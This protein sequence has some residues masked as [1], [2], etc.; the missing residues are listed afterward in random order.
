MKK[1]NFVFIFTFILLI[2]FHFGQAESL[3]KG[4]SDTR[5]N[6]QI[7]SDEADAVLK[8]L[9]KGEKGEKIIEAD[10]QNVFQ[11]EGY[12][13]LKKREHSM[14]R[15][16]ED[17]DFKTFALSDDLF[18]R[19][20]DLAATLAKW[21]ETDA[22]H[23]GE[24][25]LAYLPQNAQIRAKVYPVI[26]PKDNSFVFEVR[27]NPAIFL[28]LDPQ[29]TKEQFEN[30]LAHELHHIGFGSACPTQKTE[31][32]IK[33]LSPNMQ[34][35]LKWTGAFGEGFAVLAAA[36]G[37]D[38]HPHKFSPPEEKTRW[39]KDVANFNSDLKT[40][41][42]FFLDLADGKLSEDAEIQQV[43]SFYGEQGAWYTVGWQ[44]AVVIEKTFGR[45]KLIEIMCDQRKL[46]QTY[47]KA[48]QEYN[49]RNKTQLASWSK[50]LTGKYR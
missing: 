24:M 23:A 44:M 1:S 30:T 21:K 14:S 7:V 12:I 26:K 29:V 3:A 13:R 17:A 43:R 39:D 9:E 37:A 40:V 27:E 19:R 4:A 34:K 45:E 11:S 25:A 15:S 31:E 47:N 41:E 16:F 5:V 50:E 18:K 33:Q 2:V 35:V 38:V 28:Y 10:W 49:R 20:Q 32:E 42:K 22:N 6:I 46:L 8:I 48:I 36:G